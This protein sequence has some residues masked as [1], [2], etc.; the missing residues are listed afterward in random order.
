MLELADCANEVCPFSG[1]P[2]VADSL[3]RFEGRVVGFCNP[4]CRDKFARE[5]SAYPA[6]VE[7]FRAIPR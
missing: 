7:L 4:G 5:P 1:K 2:V 6:A 3:T